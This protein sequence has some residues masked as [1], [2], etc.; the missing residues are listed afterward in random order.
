[1]SLSETDLEII[2]IGYTFAEESGKIG[3]LRKNPP[4]PITYHPPAKEEQISNQIKENPNENNQEDD[5]KN[6]LASPQKNAEEPKEQEENLRKEEQTVTESTEQQQHKEIHEDRT[7]SKEIP[8]NENVSTENQH[9]DENITSKEETQNEKK[10]S[11]NPGSPLK[12]EQ[13]AEQEEESDSDD[14]DGWINPDNISQHF[15]TS[16]KVAESENALGIAIM[17]S[18]FA[19]QV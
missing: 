13:K 10:E 4:E 12:N 9:N 8:Q 16:Q 17:T 15:F 6:D 14:G 3:S 5:W 19:M 11:S 1:M 7:I 18:D 2:A